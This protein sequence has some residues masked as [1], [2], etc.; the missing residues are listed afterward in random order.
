MR[1][2][3]RMMLG[4]NSIF[5]ARCFE[6]NF[7]GT[8]FNVGVDL[9]NKLPDAWRAF[10]REFVSIY[11]DR[12]PGKT[13]IGA[14]LACGQLWTVSK[15]MSLGDIVLCPDGSGHYHVAEVTGVPGISAVKK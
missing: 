5:A 14:G 9:T 4:K 7:I 3:R 2:Y 10:N 1:N 11:Q 15:G 12:N 8:D 6:G 13:K